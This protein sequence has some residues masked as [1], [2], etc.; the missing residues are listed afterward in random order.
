MLK[1]NLRDLRH[2]ESAKEEAAEKLPPRECHVVCGSAVCYK[3]GFKGTS[4]AM[5]PIKPKTLPSMVS[6]M[7][8]TE[9]SAMS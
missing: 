3:L 2:P 6:L 5:L 1:H 7:N 8:C 9:P 4:S